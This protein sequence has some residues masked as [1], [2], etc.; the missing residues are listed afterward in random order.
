MNQVKVKDGWTVMEDNRLVIR[1]QNPVTGEK[2]S[3]G[4]RVRKDF[5]LTKEE[6][7]SYVKRGGIACVKMIRKRPKKLSLTVSFGLL[8]FCRGDNIFPSLVS[9]VELPKYWWDKLYSQI[10]YGGLK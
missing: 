4:K 7:R 1:W 3:Q 10:A 8:K 9:D 2:V 5:P 6:R